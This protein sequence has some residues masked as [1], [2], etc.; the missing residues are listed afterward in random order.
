MLAE[1][2]FVYETPRK[3]DDISN[4]YFYHTTEMPGIGLQEGGWDL[5]GRFDDYIGHVDV[6]GKRVLDIGTAS[7]FLSFSAEKRGARE[8]VS[9]D[10]DTA[11]RQH[12]LPFAAKDYYQNHAK[13]VRDQ[14]KAFDGWKN[15]YWFAHNALSSSARVV[16]GDI[17]E[18]PP[19]IG[20]FDVVIVGAVL[21]HLSD[22]I[23]ALA[24][25]SRVAEDTI[26]INTD[27]LD[28]D[29]PLARFNGHPALPQNDFVFWTYSLG[30]YKSVLAMLGFDIIRIHK[31]SF[32][33][34]PPEQGA[35][36]PSLDRAAIVARRV[37]R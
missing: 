36:R 10:I 18:L 23:R 26:V 12:L 30:I 34:T 8:V 3:I 16:Y 11:E 2:Q 22:P 7:G 4:C 6:S 35:P 28:D 15:G 24:S 29:G 25:I 37:G 32:L 31:D 27:Y 17:Y 9:F 1:R 21:E 13:W 20:R 19:G 5:R 14:T 33:G